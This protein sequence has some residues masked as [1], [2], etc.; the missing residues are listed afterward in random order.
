MQLGPVH[1]EFRH[2]LLEGVQVG[3]DRPIHA[4]FP[5]VTLVGDGYH[6]GIFVDIESD[7]SLNLLHVLVSFVG[8]SGLHLHHADRLASR[9]QPALPGTSTSSVCGLPH[10]PIVSSQKKMPAIPPDLLRGFEQEVTHRWQDFLSGRP[11]FFGGLNIRKDKKGRVVVVCYSKWHNRE[12]LTEKEA[13]ERIETA[14]QEVTA[15]SE[16]FLQLKTEIDVAGVD[17]EFCYDYGTAA[18]VVAAERRGVFKSDITE[19]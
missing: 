8:G 5:G 2:G 19:G 13:R 6:G 4:H 12:S 10:A 7:I 15:L 18:V 14:K 11:L 1:P 17:F 3:A 9:E 16:A